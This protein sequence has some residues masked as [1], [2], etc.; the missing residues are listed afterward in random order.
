MADLAPLKGMPLTRLDLS[1][2]PA[3][4]L[5]PL[6]GMPLQS[7][8]LTGTA[9]RDLTPLAGAPLERLACG[10]AAITD[11]APLAGMPLQWLAMAC[12]AR[13]ISALR[14]MPLEELFLGS[15]T[16]IQ[17]FSALASL[18][19]LKHLQLIMSPIRDLNVLAGLPIEYLEL[20]ASHN[21]VD[22]SPLKKLPRL[23]RLNLSQVTERE[24]IEALAGL[25]LEWLF[26]D[27]T[28][29]K[30]LT[31]LKGMTL[32]KL[33]V[34]SRQP[35]LDYSPLKGMPIE[36]LTVGWMPSRYGS[37]ACLLPD[38]LGFMKEL[39]T[40]KSLQFGLG[41]GDLKEYAQILTVGDALRAAN[42]DYKAGAFYRLEGGQITEVWMHECGIRN[43][44]PLQGLKL[45]R[46][47]AGGIPVTDLK[48]LAGMPLRRL[49]LSNVAATDLTPLEG[50]LLVSLDL[51]GTPVSDL[52]PVKGAPLEELGLV[53]TKVTDYS[54][55]KAMKLRRLWI[56]EN[57]PA[58]SLE[59]VRGLDTLTH[60]N[61]LD[62]GAFW[63]NMMGTGENPP[64]ADG[65]EA[66]KAQEPGAPAGVTAAAMSPN[67]DNTRVL[68]EK[69]LDALS[70]F[71]DKK[72]GNPERQKT[73]ATL[74]WDAE[75][76]EVAFD[77]A[78]TAIA[79]VFA[80]HDAVKMWKDDC[81][82]LWLDPMHT[83]NPEDR[84]VMV[85]LSASGAVHDWRDRD[86]KFDVE[87][88]KTEVKRTA[89]GWQGMIRVPWKGLGLATPKPGDVWGFN[90]TR[91]DQSVP[92]DLET[93]EYTSWV[94]T[95][96][97]EKLDRWGHLVFADAK[98]KPDDKAVAQA[99]A[100]IEAT[101]RKRSQA[102]TENTQDR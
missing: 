91:I 67:P 78:D 37:D 53:G 84:C 80:E 79:A 5:S 22:L 40:L 14:D 57:L 47:E 82:V 62:V 63:R 45:T 70:G 50:L 4:D 90:L 7:L 25:D 9:V 44:S 51:S 72:T 96:S 29:V 11:L 77:C 1:R 34:L 30:D 89:A 28:S 97:D 17:D 59:I 54:Q 41:R 102:I 94:V 31:P 81:V 23:K 15:A 85:Q 75:G 71:S 56:A 61:N 76:L 74:S 52:T 21:L 65:G 27:R 36:D 87:G 64:R 68:R 38:N 100:A 6:H 2:V 43:L 69:M 35:I 33:A 24:N 32:T 58:A 92:Y 12:G 46:V 26:I 55:L 3:T 18:K 13:D 16:E 83:H 66:P 42:P 10:N 99:Q 95:G 20:H 49:G 101:H 73:A 39:K 93:S 60:I 8:Q 19:S 88:L 86:P 48:P 98:A